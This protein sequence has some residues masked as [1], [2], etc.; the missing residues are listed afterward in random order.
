MECVSFVLRKS[1]YFFEY[2][3]D[4][5]PQNPC[6]ELILRQDNEEEENAAIERILG[7]LATSG[8]QLV[9]FQVLGDN[10]NFKSEIAGYQVER[11]FE[12]EAHQLILFNKLQL[13]P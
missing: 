5:V 13:S 9:V 4:P 7:N 11:V 10:V 1:P 2:Y 3:Y 12:N 8:N 6:Y